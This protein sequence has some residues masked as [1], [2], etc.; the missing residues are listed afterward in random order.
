[1]AGKVDDF[2]TEVRHWKYGVEQPATAP[3]SSPQP[4][5][6]FSPSSS[7]G[8]EYDGRIVSMQFM[9]AQDLDNL[10]EILVQQGYLPAPTRDRAQFNQAIAK[11]QQDHDLPATGELDVAT[12]AQVNQLKPGSTYKSQ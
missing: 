10:Q 2:S 8:E 12:M 6:P 7:G 1:M 4:G 11:F 5:P 3:V 9:T